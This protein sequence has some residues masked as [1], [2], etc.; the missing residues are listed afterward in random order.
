MKSIGRWSISGSES[1]GVHNFETT[2][3]KDVNYYALKDVNYEN[4]KAGLG[5]EKKID[6]LFMKKDTVA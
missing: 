5:Y 2:Q 4:K 6:Q 1:A 3:F